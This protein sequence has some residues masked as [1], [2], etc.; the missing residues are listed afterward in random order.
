MVARGYAAGQGATEVNLTWDTVEGSGYQS[1]ANVHV[2]V[3][4]SEGSQIATADTTASADGTFTVEAEDFSEVNGQ[5]LNIRS[6]DQVSVDV[7]EGSS[8]ES[9]VI[10][11]NLTAYT[12]ATLNKIYVKSL[13]NKTLGL[14]VG[15]GGA[16]TTS[17]IQ[18]DSS[19]NGIYESQADILP[20]DYYSVSYE[21][22]NGN[23]VST[24]PIAP[25]GM[26]STTDD[27]VWGFYYPPETTATVSIYS[28]GI[29]VG[30]KT[31]VTNLDG[32]FSVNNFAPQ[33][34]IKNGYKV[35]INC[36]TETN[37]FNAN[38]DAATD[39]L[40]GII[41]GKTAGGSHLIAHIEPT[42][43]GDPVDTE[44]D[45][46][47]NGNYTVSATPGFEDEIWVAAIHPDGN[48]T[49]LQV[50]FGTHNSVVGS[51]S[52]GAGDKMKDAGNIRLE[53][54][55]PLSISNQ[56]N[57]KTLSLKIK[58]GGVRFAVNPRAIPTGI[59]M[60]HFDANVS[61][62]SRTASWEISG[63]TTSTAGSILLTQIKYD[64][65]TDTPTGT[66]EVE[67]GG[68]CGVTS[69]S[70]I[71]AKIEPYKTTAALQGMI[72]EG[73]GKTG[74]SGARVSLYKNGSKLSEI[75]TSASGSF[76]FPVI[77]KGVYTLQISK[78]GYTRY[79]EEIDLGNGDFSKEFNLVKTGIGVLTPVAQGIKVYEDAESRLDDMGY[80][81]CPLSE[82]DLVSGSDLAGGLDVIF[83]NSSDATF[84]SS[85]KQS[86]SSFVSAGGTLYLSGLS[87][88]LLNY[89]SNGKCKDNQ[90]GTN[91][92]ADSTTTV[93][94]KIS[95]NMLAKYIGSQQTTPT[96]EL[97]IGGGY[98]PW[99]PINIS[100]PVVDGY[101]RGDISLHG[102]AYP[103]APL[104]ATMEVG[105]GNVLYT[106]CY[107]GKGSNAIPSGNNKLISFVVSSAL[108][109][110]RAGMAKAKLKH[111]GYNEP[112]VYKG[113]AD[114]GDA[115]KGI[116]YKSDISQNKKLAIYLADPTAKLG[117]EL[118]MPDG[119]TAT[120]QSDGSNPVGVV[121]KNSNPMTG[122]WTC[123]IKPKGLQ[124]GKAIYFLI[125]A[126]A[127]TSQPSGSGSS[128]G[129]SSSEETI[130]K[131]VPNR[132]TGLKAVSLKDSIELSWNPVVDASL[133]GYNIYRALKGDEELYKL[134]KTPLQTAKFV[135]KDV[136]PGNLYYYVVSSIGKSGKESDLSKFVAASLTE[137][138]GEIAF[139]DVP[140]GAWYK[141]YLSKLYFAD[142][143]GGYADGTF[144]PQSSI[145]RA[146]FCKVIVNAVG[147]DAVSATDTTTSPFNDIKGN[148]GYTYINQAYD[149]GI[150]SGYGDGSFR[151]NKPI[152][153]AEIAKM[154]CET[155]EFDE[156]GKS[157]G[158]SDCVNYWADPYIATLKVN[159]V[160]TG[161]AGNEFRPQ[162]YV[163]RAETCKIV[164]L[165]LT[166]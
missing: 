136:K 73:S 120:A 26:V 55:R 128:G 18:T 85:Q 134:N 47:A 38:L 64:T 121:Y 24:D 154:I 92:I 2:V 153:R 78:I 77:Q 83:V 67:L 126:K 23:T 119:T 99:R 56:T 112:E 5:T 90:A 145:T 160:V 22:E 159:G 11:T 42:N 158:Y 41:S 103:G 68:N 89:I 127:S 14:E 3:R 29:K 135:D 53:E 137:V 105:S 97:Q 16:S 19:G 8:I 13:P 106:S 162:N 57:S 15:Y 80:P 70:L 95:S 87:T 163:T 165:M 17:D 115:E 30:E 43:G 117:L 27:K 65:E 1:G 150:I 109:S 6:G 102:T 98:T 155:K 116:S 123:N 96:I 146:E 63:M 7:G 69:E 58:T 104:V 114:S 124:S 111:E 28:G 141:E 144:K 74:I 157:S 94:A 147:I 148:W 66:V 93:N 129:G 48:I 44:A 20:N 9:D 33:K 166:N 131:K 62:D 34:D 130:D 88:D 71:N 35:A 31:A 75:K 72:V 133:G 45:A 101:V 46:L 149:L 161:Y 143:L 21:D 12:S 107:A 156:I 122:S 52:I 110:G 152:T 10:N 81:V 84:T 54:N 37:E 113:I 60:Q 118:F 59:G 86:L 76:G 51:P 25:Y 4:S 49:Q 140:K 139:R 50:L 142:V 125:I 39:F 151:P 40:N 138:L 100:Q 108:A 82:S 32:E 79:D 132:P 36:S 164:W 91:G 61:D